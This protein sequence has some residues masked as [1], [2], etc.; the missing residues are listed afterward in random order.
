MSRRLATFHTTP[1]EYNPDSSLTIRP[2]LLP[3]PNRPTSMPAAP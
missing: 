3:S 2:A 1:I